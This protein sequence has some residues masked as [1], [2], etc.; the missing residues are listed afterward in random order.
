MK[1]TLVHREAEL[2]IVG[3]VWRNQLVC[4]A[5]GNL[6]SRSGR[7]SLRDANNQRQIYEVTSHVTP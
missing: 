4:S 1:V 6:N 2:I 3:S 7:S 5:S